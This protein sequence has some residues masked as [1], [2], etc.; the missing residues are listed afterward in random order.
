MKFYCRMTVLFSHIL[1][2]S[3][4]RNS[5]SYFF[6]AVFNNNA[7]EISPLVNNAQILDVPDF[8]EVG[9]PVRSSRFS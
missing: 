4:Q 5:F 8:Q 3:K 2:D 1:S 9:H 7:E 6:P